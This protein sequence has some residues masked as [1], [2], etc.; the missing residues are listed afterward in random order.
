MFVQIFATLIVLS[1][2]LGVLGFAAFDQTK[3]KLWAEVSYA[4][5]YAFGIGFAGV[6]ISMIWGI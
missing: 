2:V 1:V 6:I 5:V 3:R 4:C